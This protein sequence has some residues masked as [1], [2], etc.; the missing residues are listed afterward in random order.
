VSGVNV[1]SSITGHLVTGP[2]ECKREALHK[3]APTRLGRKRVRQP[4]SACVA[5]GFS[6]KFNAGSLF[7]LKAEATRT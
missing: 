4:M 3:I 7:R 6:R 2:S 5:S 1:L